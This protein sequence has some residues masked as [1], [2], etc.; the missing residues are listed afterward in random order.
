MLVNAAEARESSFQILALGDSLTAGYD[1]K[2]EDSFPAQLEKA[3]RAE[4]LLVTV[5]NSGVS[6]DTSAGGLARLEWALVDRPKAA[7]V[8]LGAND[9]LRGL[10]VPALEK[11][12]DAILSRLKRDNISVLLVGME[13]PRGNGAAYVEAFHHVYPSLAQRHGVPLYPFFLEGL[14]GN[15][16]LLQADGLHPTAEGVGVM[17][18]GILPQVR[19]MLTPMM[20][21]AAPAEEKR[22]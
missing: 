13:A 2:A 18:K 10:D 21:G 11:N 17:V 19:E 3:L 15:P 6:G 12:L 20:G 22:G 14:I 4:G 16:R 5:V 7:I 9:G 1:L 8:E